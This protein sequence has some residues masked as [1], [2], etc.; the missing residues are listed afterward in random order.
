MP[1]RASHLPSYTDTS[2][3]TTLVQN[4]VGREDNSDA[5]N[6]PT[7]PQLNVLGFT[8]SGYYDYDRGT[9]SD[10]SSRGY[11]WSRTPNGKI[12]AYRLVFFSTLLYPRGYYS[13]G[14]GLPLRC[15]AR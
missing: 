12:D 3:Y 11:F 4:Y 6:N 7:I 9:L 14:S 13:R 15:L 2:S 5:A 1:F 8:R 10:Q